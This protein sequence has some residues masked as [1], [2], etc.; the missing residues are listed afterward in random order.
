MVPQGIS[1]DLIATSK[2]SSASERD[3]SRSTARTAPARR[4]AEDRFGRSLVPIY[5][6][7]GTLAL[8]HE[9]FPR[10]G[11]TLADLAKLTP[12]FEKMGALPAPEAG[13]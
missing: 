3:S 2:A 4:I 9:E 12:S 6:D 8:D 5:H 7:D 13:S 1:A 11:T 10:P